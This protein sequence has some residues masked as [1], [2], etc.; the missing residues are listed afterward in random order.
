MEVMAELETLFLL[1]SIGWNV[2]IHLRECGRLLAP[3]EV[4]DYMPDGMT[5]DELDHYLRMARRHKVPP[6]IF[7]NRLRMQMSPYKAAT[8][9]Y[10]PHSKKD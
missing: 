5:Y 8:K 10:K 3:D 7:K 9:P 4:H 2:D 6:R 1:N